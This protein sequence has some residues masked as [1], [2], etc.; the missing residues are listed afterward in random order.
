MRALRFPIGVDGA[1]GGT[2]SG[3]RGRGVGTKRCN[4][5]ERNKLFHVSDARR[6]TRAQMIVSGGRFQVRQIAAGGARTHTC[7]ASNRRI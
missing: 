3:E 6:Q 2:A 4:G 5:S 1:A 7:A